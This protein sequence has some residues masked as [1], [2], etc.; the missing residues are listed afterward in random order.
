M[1]NVIIR[2]D[3]S[4]NLYKT[5]VLSEAAVRICSSKI[6]HISQ[7]NTC[8]GVSF[9]IKMQAW[10]RATLSKKTPTQV[11]SYEI[12]EIFKNKFF[13]EHLQCLLLYF[14][15]CHNFSWKLTFIVKFSSSG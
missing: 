13:T 5:E 8:V 15:D 9:L 11:F 7:E 10:R 14:Y 2:F 6:S 3:H 1:E 12:C 4:F